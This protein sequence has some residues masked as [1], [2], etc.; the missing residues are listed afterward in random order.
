MRQLSLYQ[1]QYR[2]MEGLIELEQE[3]SSVYCLNLWTSRN[4]RQF[5]N[6]NRNPICRPVYSAKPPSHLSPAV[7]GLVRVVRVQSRRFCLPTCAFSFVW[8]FSQVDLLC[9]SLSRP[10]QRLPLIFLCLRGIPGTKSHFLRSSNL[11]ISPC[12]LRVCHHLLPNLP[13]SCFSLGKG[14]GVE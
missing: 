3:A 4:P 12:C 10:F 2:F 11:V 9:V 8:R 14:M 6:A 13:L 5:Y 7:K 1:L